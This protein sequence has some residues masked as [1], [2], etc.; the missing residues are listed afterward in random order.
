MIPQ[1]STIC[2]L[3]FYYFFATVNSNINLRVVLSVRYPGIQQS[4]PESEISGNTI[5]KDRLLSEPVLMTYG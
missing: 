4:N 1:L 5:Q 3:P 2:Q